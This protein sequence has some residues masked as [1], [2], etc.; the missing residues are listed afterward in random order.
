MCT[1][2]G[3]FHLL[4]RGHF[5][6]GMDLF[7]DEGRDGLAS[8]EG[9][10]SFGTNAELTTCPQYR[11]YRSRRGRS[12]ALSRIVSAPLRTDHRGYRSSKQSVDGVNSSQGY[13]IGHRLR[14]AVLSTHVLGDTYL[15]CKIGRTHIKL[16]ICS[17]VGVSWWGSLADRSRRTVKAAVTSPANARIEYSGSQLRTCCAGRNPLSSA[18][19]CA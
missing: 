9:Q 11:V 3:D 15:C 2:H 8:Y 13:S 16:V 1:H 14:D 6:V 4:C 5:S 7:R 19:P 12:A 17:D 18:D 10:S